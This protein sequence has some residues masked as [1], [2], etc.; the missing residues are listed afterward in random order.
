MAKD[1][2]HVFMFLMIISASPFEKWLVHHFHLLPRMNLGLSL[3]PYEE[4]TD[5]SSSTTT[6]EKFS[7]WY[8]IAFLNVSKRLDVK[9]LHPQNMYTCMHAHIHTPLLL[10]IHSYSSYCIMC[11]KS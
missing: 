7:Q 2:E 3:G 5:I 11:I 9:Y 1:I 10:C 8:F 4:G 6:R